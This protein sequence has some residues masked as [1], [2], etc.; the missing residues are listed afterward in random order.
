MRAGERGWVLENFPQVNYP[1]RRLR[2]GGRERVQCAGEANAKCKKKKK[3]LNKGGV[4]RAL[5][6]LTIFYSSH[7]VLSLIYT[8]FL[9]HLSHFITFSLFNKQMERKRKRRGVEKVCDGKEGIKG[10]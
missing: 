8:L 10:V 1:G 9:H 3:V 2:G 5:I 6:L 7:S 4:Y